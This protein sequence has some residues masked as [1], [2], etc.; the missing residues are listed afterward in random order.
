MYVP[1]VLGEVMEYIA[2]PRIASAKELERILAEIAL[3]VRVEPIEPA[4]VCPQCSESHDLA[5]IQGCL[6]CLVCGYKWDCHGW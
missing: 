4:D 5:K 6:R 3:S 2:I 1:V